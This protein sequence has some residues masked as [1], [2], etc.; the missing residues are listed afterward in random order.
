[1]TGRVADLGADHTSGL[2][3]LSNR[4]CN[5]LN[6]VHTSLVDYQTL[7]LYSPEGMHLF[8]VMATY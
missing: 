8:E 7:L 3:G 1:M 6:M 4:G 2:D 5:G